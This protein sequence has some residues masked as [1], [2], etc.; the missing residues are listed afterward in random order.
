MAMPTDAPPTKAATD[1]RIVQRVAKQ[2]VAQDVPEGEL[3]HVASTESVRW[4]NPDEQ[5][6]HRDRQPEIDQRHH[7]V[8]L[9][10]AEGARLEHVRL[11]GQVAHGDLRD[12][13]GFEHHD[14][15]L[16][17]QRRKDDLE[18][19]RQ[20]D[21]HEHLHRVQAERARRL[22]LALRHRVEARADDLGGVGRHVQRHGEDGGGDRIEPDPE[23]RQ[24]EVDEEELHQERRVPDQL[25]IAGDGA[26]Q[27]PAAAP[28]AGGE[29]DADDRAEQGRHRDEQQRHRAAAHDRAERVVQPTEVEVGQRFSP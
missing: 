17:G 29:Q 3:D 20:H 5:A 25:D 16:A 14:D 13:G 1:S 27:Q 19:L 9:E 2:Q 21:L 11:E 28:A 15:D 18:R 24:A 4:P 6:P 7:E 26:P 22:L 12:D 10:G 23:A 8:G